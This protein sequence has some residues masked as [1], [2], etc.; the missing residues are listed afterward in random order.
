MYSII[1]Q[2]NLMI[3]VMVLLFRRYNQG[4]SYWYDTVLD[5]GIIL[6]LGTNEKGLVTKKWAKGIVFQAWVTYS[7]FL[8]I[9]L[10]S[11]NIVQW[12]GYFSLVN[13]YPS[14]PLEYS[15]SP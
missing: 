14:P 2:N 9:C 6:L 15:S 7:I 12:W 13:P 5:Y 1:L 10:F 11:V 3:F 8:I 4:I